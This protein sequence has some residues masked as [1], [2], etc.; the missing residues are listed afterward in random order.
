MSK[1]RDITKIKPIDGKLTT[2]LEEFLAFPEYQ[3]LFKQFAEVVGY[4]GDD[5]LHIKKVLFIPNSD[6]EIMFSVEGL[7]DLFLEFQLLKQLI[8]KPFYKDLL[9]KYPEAIRKIRLFAR[10]AIAGKEV[11]NID[12]IKI[13]NT[14]EYDREREQTTSSEDSSS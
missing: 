5:S 7:Y 11:T 12:L 6:G 2:L 1:R 3:E 14:D 9:E 13:F 4:H 10:E 8:D